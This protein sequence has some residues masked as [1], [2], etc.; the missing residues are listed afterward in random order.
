MGAHHWSPCQHTGAP[1]VSTRGPPISP[2]TGAPVSPH[3]GAPS[4]IMYSR[5]SILGDSKARA[6]EHR[7]TRARSRSADKRPEA[8]TPRGPCGG[9]AGSGMEAHAHDGTFLA[10]RRN[11]SAG[12]S[13]KHH[14]ERERPRGRAVRPHRPARQGQRQ[15]ARSGRRPW[16]G[17]G[18]EALL[19]GAVFRGDG[20]FRSWAGW[21]HG[22]VGAR[23][24]RHGSGRPAPSLR[25]RNEEKGRHR[26]RSGPFRLMKRSASGTEDPGKGCGTRHREVKRPALGHTGL[27]GAMRGACHFQ[28]KEPPLGH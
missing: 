22:T 10:V 24:P 9:A 25:R 5:G 27:P 14:T 19:R 23:G 18:W 21:A 28:D 15:Q 12:D 6:S 4:G 1:S 16:R 2:H 7:P 26:Q 17:A 3:T 11:Y 20:V 8:G 13:G